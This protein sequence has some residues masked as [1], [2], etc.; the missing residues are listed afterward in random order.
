MN[1]KQLK[2]ELTKRGLSTDG[3]KLALVERLEQAM[4][5]PVQ[6]KKKSNATTSNE[7]YHT[8]TA[9]AASDKLLIAEKEGEIA[10]RE[11]ELKIAMQT[12]TE[13]KRRQSA[14]QRELKDLEPRLS[15]SPKLPT[16]VLL[17]ILG[18]LGK[19]AGERAACVKREWRS[20]VETAKALGMYK[21]KL[22]SVVA[23]GGR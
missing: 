18:Q 20:V 2:E 1:V 23:G 14:T 6:K 15:F 9:R 16:S 19:K 7:D 22:L 21:I 3:L 12:L 13:A 5:Q 11:A 17:S 8:L 4:Q 10:Q